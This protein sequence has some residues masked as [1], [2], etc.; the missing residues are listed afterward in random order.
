MI[1]FCMRSNVSDG[2]AYETKG[3]ELSKINLVL[4]G[5]VTRSCFFKEPSLTSDGKSAATV[6]GMLGVVVL[7]VVRRGF[8][9]WP[10]SFMQRRLVS[11]RAR[12]KYSEGRTHWLRGL[13]PGFWDSET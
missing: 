9:F 10:R 13:L 6:T 7:L 12:P 5:Q 3:V 8:G 11:H 2:I 1:L 4:I